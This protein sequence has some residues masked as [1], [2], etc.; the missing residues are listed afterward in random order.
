MN[1]KKV[2]D[3]NNTFKKDFLEGF[4]FM[5]IP[6]KES[7]DLETTIKIFNLDGKYSKIL[8]EYYS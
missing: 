1:E 4:G 3:L 6:L 5:Y 8:E 7:H 2:F